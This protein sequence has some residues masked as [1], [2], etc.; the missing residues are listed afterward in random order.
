VANEAHFECIRYFLP[1]VDGTT[2]R[3][4]TEIKD[5]RQ[6]L[7]G[8]PPVDREFLH[9]Y[10][11]LTRCD[12]FFAD[13]A[14]LIEGT[15]ERL[16]LPRI[17]KMVDANLPANG[18]LGSQYLSIVEVGG[19]YA[20]IFFDLLEFLELR[21]L[22]ITDIDSVKPSAG[23]QH[24]KC[25]VNLGQTTS[26]ACIKSWFSD[27]AISPTTL[28]AKDAASKVSGKRRIAYQ[29][30]E[31]DGGPCGRSFE[32]A[33][34]LAN[35]ALF[36]FAGPTNADREAQ[37]LAA[38]ADVKKSEFALKHALAADAWTAPR[39]IVDGLRWL[40]EGPTPPTPVVAALGA[41]P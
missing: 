3:A 26:N 15:T 7:H 30:P 29:Q 18:K 23:N 21:A 39:Y 36:S 1:R 31:A 17:V 13:K 6:G 35:G 20:H 33:F 9:Q 5:L 2:S 19:A 34:M 27:N 38:A 8:M 10:M 32:D 41:N 40:A 16:L 4:T 28:L 24:V 11:T 37:A 25:E 22:V 12:L 14:V